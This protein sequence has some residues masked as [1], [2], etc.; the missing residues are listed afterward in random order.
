MYNSWDEPVLE[1]KD[2]KKTLQTP[3]HNYADIFFFF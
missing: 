3:N 2:K 1:I